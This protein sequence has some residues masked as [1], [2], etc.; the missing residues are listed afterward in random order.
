LS[1]VF[2]NSN[3]EK[4][5]KF[6]FSQER[7][8]DQLAPSVGDNWLSSFYSFH[9]PLFIILFRPPSNLE[10][11]NFDKLLLSQ[12]S[13]FTGGQMFRIHLIFTKTLFTETIIHVIVH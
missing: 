12:F 4:V 11:P 8:V 13:E 5:K 6:P 10:S 3:K 9:P 1:Q 7:G 2:I